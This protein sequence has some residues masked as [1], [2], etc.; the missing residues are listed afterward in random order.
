[1]MSDEAAPVVYKTHNDAPEPDGFDGDEEFSNFQIDTIAEAMALLSKDLR[2]EFQ[3][4]IEDAVTPLRERVI[5]LEAQISTMMALLNIDSN[6]SIEA[7]ETSTIR[8][9]HVSR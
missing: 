8:K 1:M 4:A 9:L 2:S 6:R 3:A 7:S 5:A